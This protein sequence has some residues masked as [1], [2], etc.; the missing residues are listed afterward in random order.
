MC[1]E[2]IGAAGLLPCADNI[3][4]GIFLR[5]AL[6]ILLPKLQTVCGAVAHSGGLDMLVV[7]DGGSSGDGEVG[8][9]RRG[10]E[11]GIRHVAQVFALAC[12]ATP[13]AFLDVVDVEAA[14]HVP[15]A[16]VVPRA[17]RQCGAGETDVGG[18]VKLLGACKHVAE[19]P[20]Y[21][22]GTETAVEEEF[23]AVE[24]VVSQPAVAAHVAV[25]AGDL[26]LELKIGN[27]A[28]VSPHHCHLRL[29]DIVARGVRCGCGAPVTALDIEQ[30]V[31]G[32]VAHTHVVNQFLSDLDH[33]ELLAVTFPAGDLIHILRVVDFNDGIGGRDGF[34]EFAAVLHAHAVS[35]HR[36]AVG[37]VWCE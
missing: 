26:V 14:S 24:V 20:F 9:E 15:D 4:D 31:G 30:T 17:F 16:L 25:M 2:G 36:T 12:G 35:G 1:R 19:E 33:V 3:E 27:Q 10:E 11:V 7:L 18:N 21:G 6:H 22:I 23:L 28:F 13:L 32:C 8:A 34:H 37:S 29:V 5:T